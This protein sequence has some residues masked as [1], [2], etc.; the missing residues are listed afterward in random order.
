MQI[1][2]EKKYSQ[3]APVDFSFIGSADEIAETRSIA[4]RERIRSTLENEVKSFLE[5]G[6]KINSVKP[7]VMSDPPKRP[8]NSYGSKP[9]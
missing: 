8:E 9:I 2:E 1:K 7:N 5:T 4:S 6:G 3:L